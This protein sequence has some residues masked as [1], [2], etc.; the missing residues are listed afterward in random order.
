MATEAGEPPLLD[1]EHAAFIASGVS[2]AVASR[3]ESNHPS[4]IR[5]WGCRVSPDRRRVSVFV[6]PMQAGALLADLRAGRPIAAV[7]SQPSS[8]RTIQLKAHRAE[9]APCDDADRRSIADYVQL[10]AVVLERVGHGSEFALPY[11]HV[12]SG[13][14]VRVSFEV[15]EAFAQ[16]PGPRA[17]EPLRP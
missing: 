6:S 10:F 4:V 9:V 8:H 16:T 13:L 3:D 15:S 14:L 1:D 5:A 12:A 7:F 2:I 17:G 11:L